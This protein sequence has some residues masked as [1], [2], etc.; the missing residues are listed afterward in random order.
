[1]KTSFLFLS[2]LLSTI[3]V[4]AQKIEVTTT[5]GKTI[6][7]QVKALSSTAIMTADGNIAFSD[8]Q[9]VNVE[10]D[11]PYANDLR[12]RFKDS[13]FNTAQS[14]NGTAASKVVVNG[15]DINQ[16]PDLQFIEIVGY[17]PFLSNKV[18]VGIYY[19][20]PFKLGDDQ[21]ID[22]ESGKTQK[23]NGMIDALN[24]LYK[25]GW[26]YLNAYTVT[27]SNQ[28]VYHYILKRRS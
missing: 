25:N 13:P 20:Q 22:D 26:E 15:T 3:A 1:M 16:L 28:N 17:N 18:T 24:F 8:I 2:A 7:T 6:A 27:T 12:S 21:R 4:L 19:G 10:S 5:S 23:F 11:G 9:F 14:S